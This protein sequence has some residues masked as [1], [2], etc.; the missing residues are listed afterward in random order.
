MAGSTTGPVL[1]LGGLT[2]TPD[3]PDSVRSLPTCADCRYPV[4]PAGKT[5]SISGTV[6]TP[7]KV[8]ADPLYNAVVYLPSAAVEPFAPGVSCDRCGNVSGKPV[9]ATLSGSDGA[10]KLDDVP[11]GHGV[12]LVLQMGRWRRQVSIP[13]LVECQDNPLPEELTRFPRNRSEGDIPRIGLVTSQYD[14]E[15]CILRKIGIEDGEF[16]LP[17]EEGRVHLFTG[18]GAY[19]SDGAPTGTALW[20]DP[21]PSPAT[22]WC[23]CR[24]ARHRNTFPKCG[25]KT[26]PPRQPRAPPLQ[27]TR[28]PAVACSRPT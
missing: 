7:A 27:A 25:T 17:S 5:T 18:E 11:A 10:F 9:A 23:C 4:C 2:M 3:E 16:T 19:H 24:A 22:T 1:G 14:P 13:E 12:S 15:E 8:A 21:R 28:T 20:S 6:R 26:S